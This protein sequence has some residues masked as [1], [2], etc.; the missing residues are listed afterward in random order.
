MIPAMMYSQQDPLAL[1]EEFMT[2][3]SMLFFKW[4]FAAPLPCSTQTGNAMIDGIS[5]DLQALAVPPAVHLS[6]F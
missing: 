1:W 4:A 6:K 5:Q 3:L 2:V